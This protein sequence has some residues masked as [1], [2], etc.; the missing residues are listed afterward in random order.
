MT[1]KEVEEIFDCLRIAT[2]DFWELSKM[3]DAVKIKKIASYKKLQLAR[4][5]AHSIKFD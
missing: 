3:E 4:L 1:K 2:I 5:A